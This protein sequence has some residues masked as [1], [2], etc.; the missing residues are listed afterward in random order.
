MSFPG[1]AGD[2]G[3]QVDIEVETL[4]AMLATRATELVAQWGGFTPFGGRL[5]EGDAEP[6]LIPPVSDDD[7]PQAE[8]VIAELTAAL[9]FEAESGVLRA[10]GV[11]SDVL[12]TLPEEST[13]SDAVRVA[14]EHR[15]APP[16][17]AYLPY[18]AGD[19]GPRFEQMIRTPA[20]PQVF[21]A[22]PD[23]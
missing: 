11:A 21:G 8:Q 2:T 7:F 4:L 23:A 12:V 9:R 20:D 5:R 18:R 10:C 22:H 1:G 19:A 15:H 3:E 14:V 17:A 6:E 13:P 16:V